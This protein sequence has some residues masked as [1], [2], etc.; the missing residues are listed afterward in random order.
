M[1][2]YTDGHPIDPHSAYIFYCLELEV[3]H[4]KLLGIL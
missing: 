1:Y 4:K 2:S 3:R